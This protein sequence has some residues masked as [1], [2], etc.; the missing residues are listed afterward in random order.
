MRT[1]TD[2]DCIVNRVALE[3]SDAC[4]FQHFAEELVGKFLA[5][6]A[7]IVHIVNHPCDCELDIANLRDE[8]VYY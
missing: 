7:V 2:L 3:R 6:E 5:E 8:R 1:G 4:V